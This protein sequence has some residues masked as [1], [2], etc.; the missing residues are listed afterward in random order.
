MA[1]QEQDLIWR[2]LRE[3]GRLGERRVHYLETT[4]STND[5]ALA[6]AESG[7]DCTLVVAESQ[8]RGRGRLR[9]SWH[10]PAGAGLYLSFIYRPRLEPEDLARLT[11]AA[12]LALALAVA[13]TTGLAPGL[14][15]PNDLLLAGKKCGGILC[16]CR[17]PASGSPAQLPVVVVGIGLNVNTDAAR[18]PPELQGR[19]TSLLLA[20]GRPWERGPLLAA[21]L[22]QLDALVVRLEEGEFPA[23]LAQWRQRDALL[24]RELEWLTPAGE[25]VRGIALGPDDDGILRIR[26]RGGRVHPVL[27]G[28]LSLAR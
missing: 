4:E 7:G 2:R 26:D 23:I 12:G 21:I 16:E 11:L 8:S 13:E 22:K 5:L 3:E 9:R 10:S 25:V 24:G 27:S 1:N 6:L 20:T 15:W 14:K 17:L 18:I 19:A 28:D